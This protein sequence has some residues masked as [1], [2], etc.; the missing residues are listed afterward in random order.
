MASNP[1]TKKN[2]WLSMWLSGANAAMGASRSRASA[3]MRRQASLA[4]TEGVEQM[5]RLW[6]DSMN[7][8][9]TSG[10]RKKRR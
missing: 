4:M 8:W 7:A 10:S 2:P 5:T 9:T 1:W 6:I 3:E